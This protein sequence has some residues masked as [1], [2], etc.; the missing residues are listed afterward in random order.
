MDQASYGGMNST[1]NSGKLRGIIKLR[2]DRKEIGMGYN[3]KS[4][5]GLDSILGSDI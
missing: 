3:A 1:A 2:N 4:T 5:L